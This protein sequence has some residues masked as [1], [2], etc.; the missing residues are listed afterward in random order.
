MQRFATLIGAAAVLSITG[1][2]Q[3]R[4][5]MA[6][7]A[8]LATGM[9]DEEGRRG[10]DVENGVVSSDESRSDYRTTEQ[11]GAM[12]HRNPKTIRNWIRDFQLGRR[13][14]V[15]VLPGHH[16]LIHW[17]TFEKEFVRQLGPD[18]VEEFIAAVAALQPKKKD[19]Q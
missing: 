15:F 9:S 7:T 17:P 6:A 1:T 18:G 5:A 8:I 12:L 4:R 10:G 11:I 16:Y 2:G 3:P 13:H 19:E 14:G